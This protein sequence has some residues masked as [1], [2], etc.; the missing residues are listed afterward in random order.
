MDREV[1]LWLFVKNTPF[2]GLHSRLSMNR[3]VLLRPLETIDTA[4]AFHCLGRSKKIWA[5]NSSRPQK[6]SSRAKY[7]SIW[8]S[9]GRVVDR[10]KIQS[11]CTQSAQSNATILLGEPCSIVSTN[12]CS[13][14]MHAVVLFN[15]FWR[16]TN[17]THAEFLF[18]YKRLENRSY[19]L[20]GISD[21]WNSPELL[22]LTS[23]G[24][25]EE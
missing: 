14:S 2:H 4:V 12:S 24:I 8:K 17:D 13:Q 18:W 3:S 10:Q 5:G 23:F 25:E 1:T 15:L 21:S 22:Y 11:E 9:S 19:K 16:A 7:I 6:R 20:V